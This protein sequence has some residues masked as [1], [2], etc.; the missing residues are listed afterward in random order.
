MPAIMLSSMPVSPKSGNRSEIMVYRR[1]ILPMPP[2][3]PVHQPGH[4]PR[5]MESTSTSPQ[6]RS[7]TGS[8]TIV[9][10]HTA[11]GESD[12]QFS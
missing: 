9:Y 7:G 3:V 1:W 12:A 5:E 11:D 6:F 10:I 4:F 8:S 2:V